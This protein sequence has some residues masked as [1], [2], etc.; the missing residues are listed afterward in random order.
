VDSLQGLS[1]CLMRKGEFA[2]AEPYLRQALAVERKLKNATNLNEILI[3]RDLVNILKRLNRVNEIGPLLVDALPAT[4]ELG[5]ELADLLVERCDSFARS[6]HWEDARA[7]A[8][9][10]LGRDSD[11]HQSY[12]RLAPLLVQAGDL[13]EYQK[14]CRSILE[15][16]SGTTNAYVADRMAKDCLLLSSSGV[17]LQLVDALAETAVTVGK[18]QGAMPYF[19][20]CKALVEYRQ[21]HFASAIEWA[22]KSLDGPQFIYA[23]AEAYPV[24]A[25]AHHRLK[26]HDQAKAALAK[27]TE[28]VQSKL[29]P[30]G[31]GDL[32][33]DWQGW[34]FAQALMHEAASLIQ[35]AA[36]AESNRGKP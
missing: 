17:D 28:L 25:M 31:S 26:Q 10:I 12:H 27:G 29:P 14:L 15:H 16:F 35:P 6:G 3:L 18:D 22:Q 19:Q 21:G 32:G 8:T 7:D 11:D 24:L 23:Q 2:A 30:M 5:A 33:I 1:R 9:L 13:V 34:I 20:C 36:A 4:N